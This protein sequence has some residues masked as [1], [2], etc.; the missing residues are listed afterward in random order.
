M[1]GMRRLRSGKGEFAYS[2]RGLCFIIPDYQ[3]FAV[4]S[5]FITFETKL[6]ISD[7]FARVHACYNM[8][9]VNMQVFF[10]A[11]IWRHYLVSLAG[12]KW[13]CTVGTGAL[14]RE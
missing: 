8:S 11:R 4:I 9:Y 14:H 3:N 13:F 1:R 2:A 12:L 7:D 6:S 10:D 5:F